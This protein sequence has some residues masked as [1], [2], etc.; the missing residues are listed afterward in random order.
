[1]AI[2]WSWLDESSLPNYPKF[3]D[4]WHRL[5]LWCNPKENNQGVSF[6]S[7]NSRREMFFFRKSS[8]AS[9]VSQVG[10]SCDIHIEVISIS[11]SSGHKNGN[12]WILW[13]KF[14]HVVNH[15]TTQWVLQNITNFFVRFEGLKAFIQ[16]CASSEKIFFAV[17]ST[18][19]FHWRPWS[20]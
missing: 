11:S 18:H 17:K 9:A 14:Y 3:V 4:C 15:N 5:V 6:K 13:N 12:I 8:V 10:S 1:M 20:P 16:E 2:C 7:H 19:L